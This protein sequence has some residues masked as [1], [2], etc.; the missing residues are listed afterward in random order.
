MEKGLVCAMARLRGRAAWLPLL[1]LTALVLTALAAAWQPAGAQG[2]PFNW[3]TQLQ[4]RVTGTA[5]SADGGL[6][7][8]GARSGEVVLAKADG[9]VIARWQAPL[10]GV[11]RV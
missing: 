1:A 10:W 5:L 9:E 8:F 2:G 6:M 3:H 11:G 4:D 7:L